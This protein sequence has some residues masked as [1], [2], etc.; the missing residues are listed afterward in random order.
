MKVDELA[1]IA[2][3]IGNITNAGRRIPAALWG[4][5]D[6][7]NKRHKKH[8]RIIDVTDEIRKADCIKYKNVRDEKGQECRRP[9]HHLVHSSNQGGPSCTFGTGHG[10]ESS[11]G[12]RDM[13]PASSC[14]PSISR[15][16]WGA[17][18]RQKLNELCK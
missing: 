11:M 3:E 18:E 16:S 14:V 17:Y 8:D 4:K 12:D 5:Y 13:F 10:N 2:R 15:C 6:R 7:L 1:E 9:G